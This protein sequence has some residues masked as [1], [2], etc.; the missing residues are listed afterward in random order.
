M[1]INYKTL[2]E[3]KLLHEFYLTKKDGTTV[4]SVSDQPNRLKFLLDEYTVG[5]E[6][7]N[8]DISFEFPARTTQ[9]YDAHQLKLLPTY[10]GFR[11]LARVDV[12]RLSDNSIVYRPVVPI[13][14]DLS[15]NI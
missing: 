3:V 6:S 12:I 11:V 1:A 5:R 8:A 10:S 14:E 7:I 13:E 9:V 4:F 15:I 2:F